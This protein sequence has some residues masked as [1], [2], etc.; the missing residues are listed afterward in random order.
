M[1]STRNQLD[2]DVEIKQ[3]EADEGYAYSAG[4]L[5]SM[6]RDMLALLPKRK[7]KEFIQQLKHHN[8]MKMVAVKSLMNGAECMIPRKNLGTVS[9]PSTERHWSM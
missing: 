5:S 7:Q 9:D 3:M 8:D 2:L 6:V 4:Y 1:F